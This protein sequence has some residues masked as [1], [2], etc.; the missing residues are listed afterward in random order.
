MP[1]RKTISQL[2]ISISV[3]LAGITMQTQAF[4]SNVRNISPDM[5][6][7]MQ[8][9]GVITPTNPVPCNRLRIVTFSHY[10]FTGEVHH[11]GQIMVM[12]AVAPSVISIF[13]QLFLREFPI[14]RA[15]LINHYG[16][17][18]DLSLADNNTSSFNSRPVVGHKVLS[19]HAYGLAIDINPLQN[20]FISFKSDAAIFNPPKGIQYTN[21][22]NSRPGKP[23]RAGMAEEVVG[24][25]ARYGF[26]IWGGYWDN[27]IDYQHFQVSR[28]MAEFMAAIPADLATTFFSNYA[29]HQQ[30]YYQHCTDQHQHT[31]QDYVDSL[32][33]RFADS[34]QIPLLQLYREIPD[35]L[36]IA[37]RNFS[38][39]VNRDTA[40][41]SPADEIT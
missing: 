6:T 13:K 17:D 23:F 12:D 29:T 14:A 25:F 5:C 38:S 36:A 31:H 30:I 10:D 22:N 1:L 18:D 39:E 16:G 2:L 34:R 7:T 19:I 28:E 3:L 11:N 27:P 35:I 9:S 24:I 20:P 40:C 21:R 32:K 4:Q 8:Q 41:P 37:I 26:K 15:K 33:Q